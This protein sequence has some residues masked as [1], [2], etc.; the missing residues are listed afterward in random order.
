[1]RT[2]FHDVAGVD[3]DQFQLPVMEPE[4]VVAAS[5]KGLQLREVVCLP[6]LE[7]FELI[8]A[9]NEAQ[10]NILRAAAQGSLATRYHS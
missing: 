10:R 1:V 2:E 8:E 9:A 3:R 4:E 7:E 6:S 5:L